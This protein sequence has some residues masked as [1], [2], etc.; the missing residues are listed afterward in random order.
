MMPRIYVNEVIIIS[1]E[2]DACQ[3]RMATV[4]G[5]RRSYNNTAFN[6][7]VKYRN[8]RIRVFYIKQM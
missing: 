5:S 6:I 2:L 4:G 8:K 7:Y 3:S 1:W